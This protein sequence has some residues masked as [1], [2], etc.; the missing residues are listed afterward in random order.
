MTHPH[1]VS[2]EGGEG[3]GKSTVITAAAESLRTA[4]ETVLL[5]R[6]PGGTAV[7]E[8]V[9]AV[10]LNPEL[11]GLCA[12]SELLLMMA[13]R[14][15]LVR[16][17]ILPALERGEWVL[18]DRFT[19][20]SFAYQGGGRGIDS[21][22][23]AELERWV[24]GLKPGLSFLLDLPVETGL[25]RAGSRAAPD[26]IEAESIAFFERVR[27]SYRSRAAAEPQRWCVLDASRPAEAVAAAVV[28]RLNIQRE[29]SR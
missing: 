2:F 28:Q 24:A 17:R 4:G 9:R 6:E 18:C 15:Q 10:L 22:R 20:A 29:V 5:L 13:S 27:A 16:E 23:I 19:D 14:A 25:A 3:A 1:F 21:G 8:A 11:R 12:E 26:R 7:G